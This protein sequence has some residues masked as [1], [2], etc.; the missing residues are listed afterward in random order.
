MAYINVANKLSIDWDCVPNQ[1]DPEMA[2]IGIFAS[3]DPVA[4]DQSCYDAVVNSK[5]P[6]KES[7]IQRMNEKHAIH[8]LEEAERLGV[9]S[10]I[11]KKEM[12]HE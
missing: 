5:D 6:K 2:D 3:L 10:R 8:A 4:I 9:G 11:W 1:K 12:Y 7:L